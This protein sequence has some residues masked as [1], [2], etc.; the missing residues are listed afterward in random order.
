[1]SGKQIELSPGNMSAAALSTPDLCAVGSA[2]WE[3]SL[4][5]CIE[6]NGEMHQS[7]KLSIINVRIG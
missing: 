4:R 1:M 2:R 7:Y 6:L 5:K 3:R